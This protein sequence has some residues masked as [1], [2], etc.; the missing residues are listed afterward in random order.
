MLSQSFIDKIKRCGVLTLAERYTVLQQK[1]DSLWLGECPNPDHEDDTPSFAVMKN[2]NGFESWCCYGC[3]SGKKDNDEN[4]GSDNIAFV[5]WLYYHKNKKLLNFPEAVT[6]LAKFYSIPMEDDKNAIHYR[7]NKARND[8][9]QSNL[10]PFVK[11]YLYSRGL[12]DT[13]ID[14]WHIGFDGERITFPIFNTYN[15]IVAFSNRA[16]SEAS[17][18]SGKK[19]I[20]SSSSDIFK[21]SSMFFGL[22]FID[23][24]CKNIFITEGQ[25]DAIIA[26]KYGIRNAVALMTCS[27]SD[28]HIDYIKAHNMNPI[29]CFDN[30]KAGRAGM[31]RAIVA[32]TAAGVKNIKLVILPDERDLADLGRDVKHDLKS[33]ISSRI[34]T[35]AQFLLKGIADELDTVI[36]AKQQE[37][38]PKI[39]AALNNITDPDEIAVAKDF[40]NRRLRMWSA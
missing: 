17:I 12:D 29:L 21:K 33:I 15:D 39:K 9:Y 5:R 28:S 8:Q 27:L 24:S 3:H 1:N 25:F 31:K 11:E 22:N 10:I 16:F 37:I 2:K 13:D 7:E 35:Y 30:D 14:K 36:V 38:M 23:H 4:F 34:V 6:I 40:I 18:R 20:N 26:N 19:Y 32:L